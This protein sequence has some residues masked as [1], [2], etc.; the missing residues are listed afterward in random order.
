MYSSNSFSTNLLG[1][2]LWIL[3]PP[4]H[5]HLLRRF[6]D[7]LR[8]ELI[9]DVRQVDENKFRGWTKAREARVEVVQEEGETIFVPSGW[10]RTSRIRCSLIPIGSI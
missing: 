4:S 6:P 9:P 7:E 1:R 2:K 8:S 3:F 5:T 10:Y